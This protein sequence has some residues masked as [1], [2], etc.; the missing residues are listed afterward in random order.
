MVDALSF[1]VALSFNS[2]QLISALP[3]IIL[4]P[5]LLANLL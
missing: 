2:V 1:S 3:K 4:V 5:F